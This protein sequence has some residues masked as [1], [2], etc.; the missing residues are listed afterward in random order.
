[1]TLDL[2]KSHETQK[3][4]CQVSND[5]MIQNDTIRL[6]WEKRKKQKRI[7]F[8]WDVKND[9]LSSAICQ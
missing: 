8:F 1:M 9:T 3:E 5:T 6:K 7:C 4:L 2:D